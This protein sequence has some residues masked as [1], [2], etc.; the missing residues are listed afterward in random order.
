MEK[1]GYTKLQLAL[2][3]LG[4]LLILATVLFVAIKWSGLPDRIPS[5]YN[6]SGEID[7]WGGRG[8]I[9]ILPVVSVVLY[10]LM[11]V[12][13]FFPR[14]WNLP[15]KVTENN[16]LAIYALTKQMVLILKVEITALFLYMTVY[17]A[18]ATPLPNAFVP[19]FLLVLFL[20][21]AYFLTKIVR[22]GKALA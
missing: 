16:R 13:S 20:T 18:R 21:I 19:V 1:L 12:V 14:L 6:A 15:V 3:A 4:A 2:E 17:M 7:A 9:L 10:A 5:H 8:Q 22:V 11:T